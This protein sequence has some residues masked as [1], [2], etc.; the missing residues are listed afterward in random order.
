MVGAGVPSPRDEHRAARDAWRALPLARRRAVVR[1]A[2]AGERSG[3]EA[4]LA[5]GQELARVRLAPPASDWDRRLG[6]VFGPWSLVGG[7][8]VVSAEA[9]V[10]LAVGVVPLAVGLTVMA[11][12][13][14]CGVVGALR[15]RADRRAA[16]LLDLGRR[17]PPV[18]PAAPVGRAAAPARAAGPLVLPA[19]AALPHQ[20]RSR[21]DTSTGPLRTV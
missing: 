7:A 4:V 18:A 13:A 14:L 8:A 6:R 19:S 21:E 11:A 2:S 10:F 5:V 3:D 9:G 16:A 17:T 12:A 15:L 1:A 20:R